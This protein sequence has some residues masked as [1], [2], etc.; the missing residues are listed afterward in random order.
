MS[1]WRRRARAAALLAGGVLVAA[2]LAQA[3]SL[4]GPAPRAVARRASP[5]PLPPSALLRDGDLVFRRGTD[6]VADAVA[7]GS[8]G[9][10]FSHVG[11]L[12]L[13]QGAPWVVH[14]AP[15]EGAGPGGVALQ[16]L[17][18]FA[19]PGAASDAAVYRLRLSPA[20]RR[21]IRA[22]ALARRGVPFDG[23][24][25]YSSDDA[26]YCTE[27]VLKALAAAGV[28]LPPRLPALDVP[29]VGEPVYAPDALRQLPGLRE[30]RPRLAPRL[31]AAAVERSE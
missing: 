28:D 16:P 9:A 18:V 1:G 20:Q 4:R 15:A 23:G 7:L 27:L 3:G 13:W 2:V 12:V 29:G 24:L 30:V 26:L 25:R 10:R 8:G 6:A 31:Q 17:A 22:Y 21:Q 14:A 19:A 5:P 11:L